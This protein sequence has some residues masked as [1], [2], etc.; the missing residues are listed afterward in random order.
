LNEGALRT[1]NRSGAYF[2]IRPANFLHYVALR[3]VAL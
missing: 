1:L 3:V 2:A